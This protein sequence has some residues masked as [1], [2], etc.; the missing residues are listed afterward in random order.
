MHH[1][2]L[3]LGESIRVIDPVTGSLGF[4]RILWNFVCNLV[5]MASHQADKSRV[6][7]DKNG[8]F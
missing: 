5:V 6:P 1:F 4:P 8:S 3:L 2:E 7:V